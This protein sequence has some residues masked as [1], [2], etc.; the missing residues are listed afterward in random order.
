MYA[1]N[2]YT[3]Y[4][5]FA[6]IPTTKPTPEHKKALANDIASLEGQEKEVVLLLIFE[7]AKFHHNL[8]EK[9]ELPYDI[10]QDGED[11]LVD[12]EKLPWELVWILIQFMNVTHRRQQEDIH[13]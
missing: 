6:N 5:T 12:V 10:T 1:R 2:N 3:L 8:L 4:Q 11:V 13:K 9:R 7:H